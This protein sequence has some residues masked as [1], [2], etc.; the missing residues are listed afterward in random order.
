MKEECDTSASSGKIS[1][2]SVNNNELGDSAITTKTDLKMMLEEKKR[3]TTT[4]KKLLSIGQYIKYTIPLQ[5]NLYKETNIEMN[6]YNTITRATNDKSSNLE[7]KR[8]QI[9]KNRPNSQNQVYKKQE[10]GF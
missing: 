9:T 10:N 2:K 1:D 3:R 8:L 5:A 7:N 6:N 4:Q